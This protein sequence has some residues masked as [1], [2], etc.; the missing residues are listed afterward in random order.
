MPPGNGEVVISKVHVQA[1]VSSTSNDPGPCAG[2]HVKVILN[3][4]AAP[5]PAPLPTMILSAAGTADWTLYDPVGPPVI[6]PPAPIAPVVTFTV[7]SAI[8]W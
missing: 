7:P 6:D 1:A 2:K 8:I 5:Y 3:G 4:L